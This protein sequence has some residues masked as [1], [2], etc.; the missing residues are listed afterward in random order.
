MDQGCVLSHYLLTCG[1][2]IIGDKCVEGYWCTTEEN[3]T[4]EN[5]GFLI[6]LLMSLLCLW[7]ALIMCIRGEFVM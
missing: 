4:K 7:V 2:G 1:W 5:G 6:Y 3:I